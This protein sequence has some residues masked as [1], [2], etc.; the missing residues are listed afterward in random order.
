[1]VPYFP[2][3][4][5]PDL[6][7]ELQGLTRQHPATWQRVPWEEFKKYPQL[8]LDILIPRSQFKQTHV[9]DRDGTRFHCI[10][11]PRGL[12]FLFAV[13]VGRF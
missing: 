11:T 10:R 5:L 8:K 6:P 2:I 7:P 1:M 12:R 13:L 4:W 3:E 9:F